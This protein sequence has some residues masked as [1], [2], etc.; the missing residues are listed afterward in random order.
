MTTPKTTAK[1]KL[2]S[3]KANL[4]KEREGDWIPAPEIG[5]GVAFLVRSTNYPAYVTARDE[6]SAKLTKKYGTERVPD[7]VMAKANGEIIADHLLLGW[8]ALDEEYDADLARDVLCD[9][10]HRTVRT[11]VLM[12]AT[13]V[14]R[15]EVQFVE[16][17]AKN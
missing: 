3:L 13:K 2:S 9:E 8:R 12:A 6:A 4:D 1:I 14:G 5:D 16:D 11:G 7:E 10:A 17:G 15:E